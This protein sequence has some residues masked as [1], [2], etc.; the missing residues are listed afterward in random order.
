VEDERRSEERSGKDHRAG[1]VHN[2]LRCRS[3]HDS[4]AGGVKGRDAAATNKG[5]KRR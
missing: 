1:S 5:C 3:A 4:P 2:R